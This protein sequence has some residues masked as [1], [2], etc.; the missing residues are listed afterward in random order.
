MFNMCSTC[1]HHGQPRPKDRPGQT[2][3]YQVFTKMS[4]HHLAP[5]QVERNSRRRPRGDEA[6]IRLRT[7]ALEEVPALDGAFVLVRE[8]ARGVV[9]AGVHDL[10]DQQ[11]QRRA[12]EDR[13]SSY[14]I[15]ITSLGICRKWTAT[16]DAGTTA[17]RLTIPEQLGD[18]DKVRMWRKEQRRLDWHVSGLG[19]A[20]SMSATK[21]K[22]PSHDCRVGHED[23]VNESWR[24][25][26]SEKAGSHN[27]A[28]YSSCTRRSGRAPILCGTR[29]VSGIDKVRPIQS[30]VAAPRLEP[31]S[32]TDSN[33]SAECI[34]GMEISS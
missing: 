21:P 17:S 14:R 33:F 32:S 5:R 34:F 19:I 13:A 9:K 25:L 1:S 29:E 4:Q 8:Q 18:L 15:R 31:Y 6:A 3:K 24:V 26:R 27:R 30:W 10:M 7:E 12:Y 22:L 11:R 2:P 23:Q 28:Y 16:V 20:P